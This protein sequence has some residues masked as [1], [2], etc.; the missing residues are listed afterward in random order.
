MKYFILSILAAQLMGCA[1]ASVAQ[2]LNFVAFD[3]QIQQQNL[4]SL[5][6]IEGK[7]CT[8]YIMGY[9]VGLDPTVR[10]AFNNASNQVED[11]LIPGQA[12]KSSEGPLKVIKNVSV[13]QGGFNAY[14]ASRRCII[15]TGAG[16]R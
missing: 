5:G 2:K 9:G 15:V 13:E 6:N 3:E 14:V 11:S 7:D 4:K 10:S 8:W 16:F 12:K 1:S